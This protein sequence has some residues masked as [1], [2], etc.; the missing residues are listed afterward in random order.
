M[1][2]DVQPRDI[3]WLAELAQHSVDRVEGGVNLFPDLSSCQD[4]LARHEDQQHDLGFDHTI[5]ETRE[6]LRFITAELSVTISQ[7]LQANG[8]LD[9]ATPDNVLYL[10]LGELRIETKLLHYARVFAGCKA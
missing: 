4:N 8:E 5:D 3:S 9:V 10:E 1:G 6:Q 7:A 2:D